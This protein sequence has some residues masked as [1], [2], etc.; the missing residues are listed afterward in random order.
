[1]ATSM[2]IDRISFDNYIVDVMI[3]SRRTIVGRGVMGSS[4]EV[5]ERWPM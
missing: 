3:D 2:V 1:M 5:L 4:E